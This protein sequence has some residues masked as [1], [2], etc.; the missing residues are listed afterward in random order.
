MNEKQVKIRSKKSQARLDEYFKENYYKDRVETRKFPHA[1]HSYP[2]AFNVTLFR[3][4]FYACPELQKSLGI[5]I[6]LK[7]KGTSD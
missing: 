5:K 4:I 3:G 6:P 2:A 1:M 7:Q